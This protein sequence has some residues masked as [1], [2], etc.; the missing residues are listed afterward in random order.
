MGA[1][2][3]ITP[4]RAVPEKIITGIDEKLG[5]GNGPLNWVAHVGI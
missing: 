3:S 4:T 1:K 5:C 2:L